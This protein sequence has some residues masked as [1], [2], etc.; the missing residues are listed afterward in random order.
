MRAKVPQAL[1]VQRPS[2]LKLDKP[3]SNNAFGH[4]I[5]LALLAAWNS[6]NKRKRY[7]T[8]LCS[9]THR[10]YNSRLRSR[11]GSPSR[12][13]SGVLLGRARFPLPPI[14]MST[15]LASFVSPLPIFAG[16]ETVISA[17]VAGDVGITLAHS[18]PWWS[19]SRWRPSTIHFGRNVHQ[20]NTLNFPNPNLR[21][22]A[23]VAAHRR[24]VPM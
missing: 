13:R 11:P 5:L 7:L 9:Y 14:A 12:R 21:V 23:W 20:P 15:S 19:W 22:G 1:R 8:L 17:R 18:S 4:N 24:L 3:S 2:I 6:R 10:R 16:S